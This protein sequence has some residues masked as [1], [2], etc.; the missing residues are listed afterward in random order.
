MVP[1]ESLR[2]TR[3]NDI[4]PMRKWPPQGFECFSAHDHD[5]CRGHFFEPLEVLRQMPGDFSARA[6]DAVERH[7]GDGFERGHER[8]CP[9]VLANDIPDLLS[10][11]VE[12]GLVAS[13]EE[14]ARLG[15]G[16][17]VTQQH[18][19]ALRA[20]FGLSRRQEF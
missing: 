16:S 5:L 20:K 9:D 15:L 2:I 18:A 1:K 7:R 14:E 10:P 19:A 17:R 4:C 3:K 11:L 13:F 8:L 12:H 6:D